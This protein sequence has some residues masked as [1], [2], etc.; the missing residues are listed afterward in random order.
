MASG[1]QSQGHHKPSMEEKEEEQ[2]QQC[3]ELSEDKTSV[4][5]MKEQR[6]TVRKALHN[7]QLADLPP[8]LRTKLAQFD[9]DGNGVIDPDELPI[10]DLGS[11]TISIRAFPTAFRTSLGVFDLNGDGT[12]NMSE[13]TQAAGLYA[14]SKKM[15]RRLLAFAGV[16]LLVICA[17]VGLTVG[18]TAVVV[19]EIKETKADGSGALVK[20]G[21]NTPVGTSKATQSVTLFDMVGQS[22]SVL[23]QV[24]RVELE[25]VGTLLGYTI[26]GYRATDATV[27]FLTSSGDVVTVDDTFINVTSV[28]GMPVYSELKS[29]TRRRELLGAVM[30]KST[31]IVENVILQRDTVLRRDDAVLRYPDESQSN[32]MCMNLYHVHAKFE[33]GLNPDSMKP[34]DKAL[35][36]EECSAKCLEMQ[37]EG[38]GCVGFTLADDKSVCYFRS[39]YDPNNSPYVYSVGLKPSPDSPNLVSRMTDYY[40]MNSAAKNGYRTCMEKK[41]PRQTQPSPT[42]QAPEAQVAMTNEMLTRKLTELQ[43]KFNGQDSKITRLDIRL[44]TFD[45]RV[46]A[47]EKRSKASEESLKALESEVSKNKELSSTLV[48]G[49]EYLNGHISTLLGRKVCC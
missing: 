6:G 20:K 32:K 22:A 47:V 36:P 9:R 2:Q 25:Q 41:R 34:K 33:G 7:V 11:D 18:L 43:G 21:T 48:G 44:D 1:Q 31:A 5:M 45:E 19:E 38:Q 10:T 26:T 42:M 35:A 27:D 40:F 23:S 16:L 12:V 24:R 17:L 39:E 29:T 49:F 46:E 3:L 14:E 30:H 8:V 15:T 4:A 13:L 37:K 28:D